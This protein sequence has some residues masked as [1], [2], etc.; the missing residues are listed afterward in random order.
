M[1]FFYD[2]NIVVTISFVIFI[3]ILGYY[4]V[5][6]LI[7]DQLD[8]RAD[9]IRGE[10]DEA[11]R[12]REEAQAT[13][14]EFER[15]QKEVAARAEDIVEHARVDARE[16]A[17]RAKADVAE[18]ITRRLK[19]ADEQIA[20]AEANAVKQVRNKAVTVAVAAAADVLRERIGD[21]KAAALIDESIE[22]VGNRLH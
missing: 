20:M 5:H 12:L 11:R 18:S 21:E 22:K 2:S 19:A 17:E 16:A 14:A 3:A 8:K 4:G 1:S 10:L 15:R 13:F 6:T 7:I 9:G